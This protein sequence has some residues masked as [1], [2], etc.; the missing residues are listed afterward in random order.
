MS[1]IVSLQSSGKLD[2]E[3]GMVKP[4][5]RGE[6]QDARSDFLVLWFVLIS[7]LSL[8]CYLYCPFLPPGLRTLRATE[9]SWLYQ[10]ASSSE[11]TVSTALR[12]L[13]A[14]MHRSIHGNYRTTVYVVFTMHWTDA[15]AALWTLSLCQTVVSMLASVGTLSQLFQIHIVLANDR[16]FEF[17]L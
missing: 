12:P 17:T 15:A 3:R 4:M 6:Q 2:M 1:I 10:P 7:P 14:L 13:T 9:Q 8:R 16:S 5:I 11:T